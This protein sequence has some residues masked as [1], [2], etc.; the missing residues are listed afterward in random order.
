[1]FQN[2]G[3]KLADYD[4]LSMNWFWP[5]DSESVHNPDSESKIQDNS[6]AR[7]ASSEDAVQTTAAQSAKNGHIAWATVSKNGAF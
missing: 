5:F 3:A 2:E 1:M 7:G 4:A 6:G